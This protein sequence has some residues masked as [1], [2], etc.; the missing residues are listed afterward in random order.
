M[1]KVLFVAIIAT[2][3][4]VGCEKTE[5]INPHLGTEI[6]FS[7]DLGKLTKA[8]GEADATLKEQGFKVTAIMAYDDPNT[9]ATEFGDIYDKINNI[10]FVYNNGWAPFAKDGENP[11]QYW[12]PGQNKDLVFLAISSAKETLIPEVTIA[13]GL[14]NEITMDPYT[15]SGFEVDAPGTSVAGENGTTTT[16][17]PDNDLMIADAVHQNQ[18]ENNK[19]VDLKFRHALS[20]VQFL[21]V[22]NGQNVQNEYPALFLSVDNESITIGQTATFTVVYKTDANTSVPLTEGYSISYGESSSLG[23]NVNVFTPTE[24]GEYT[25]TA[26]YTAADGKTYNSNA[27]DVTVGEAPS[28]NVVGRTANENITVVV[29][30]IKVANVISKGDLQVSPIW[31]GESIASSYTQSGEKATFKWVPSTSLDDKDSYEIKTDLT[32]TTEAVSYATW[33]VIPQIIKSSNETGN[34]TGNKTELQV[35]VAYTI[36]NKPFTRTFPLYTADLKEWGVNQYIKYT[37]NI[38]PELITF[39]PRV[40]DWTTNPSV[41]QNN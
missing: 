12:W 23:A 33:L 35:E 36:N 13:Q 17:N 37:I 10:S 9:E 8:E 16:L 15:I 34:E 39:N 7:P 4:A 18:A 21:F 11:Q 25:F 27:V 1:K 24:G 30:S 41:D 14:S 29:K 31:D 28:Q 26:S 3:I 20:K 19:V 5:I 38:S 40:E 6:L 2:L 32:L 22:T